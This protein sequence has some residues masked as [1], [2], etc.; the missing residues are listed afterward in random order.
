MKPGAELTIGQGRTT[1]YRL[2]L[3]KQREVECCFY[4]V[5]VLH[6]L[7]Y[8]NSGVFYMNKQY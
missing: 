5:R 6:H 7:S 1:L 4:I 2:F 3:F 8:D